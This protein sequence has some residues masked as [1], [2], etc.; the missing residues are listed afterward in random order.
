MARTPN[1]LNRVN[2]KTTQWVTLEFDNEESTTQ[3][4]RDEVDQRLAGLKLPNG[5]AWNWGQGEFRD[6]EALR[7]MLRGILISIGVV[8]LLMA[9]LFESILQAV[10]RS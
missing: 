10:W 5:Y 3:A 2:R 8:L 9:A 1:H 6:D 7:I 4:M